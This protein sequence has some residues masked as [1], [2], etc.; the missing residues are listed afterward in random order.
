[1]PE[2]NRPGPEDQGFTGQSSESDT[3]QESPDETEEVEEDE[4]DE[5]SPRERIENFR[6]LVELGALNDAEGHI[7]FWNTI[8]DGTEYEAPLPEDKLPPEVVT[9]L[10]SQ[11][12]AY[13]ELRRVTQQN[14]DVI[15]AAL[16][17]QPE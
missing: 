12:S 8:I 4:E 11:R 17:Q 3:G 2:E 16:E 9:A 15:K 1:M 13:E 6:V 10:K 5:R 14:V 7:E